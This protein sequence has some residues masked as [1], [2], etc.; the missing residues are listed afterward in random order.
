MSTPWIPTEQGAAARR[1]LR[2]T[3]SGVLATMSRE[4]PGYPFGSVTPFVTSQEG[5]PLI[6]VSTIAQHTANMQADP[7]VCLTVVESGAGN[8]QA[9]G[10]TSLVGD[11]S[12]VPA[13]A[14]EAE[15]ERYFAFFPEAREYGGTHDFRLYRIEPK[16]VRFIGGFG[17]IWWVEPQDWAVPTPAW[18]AEEADIVRHMNEDH[19]PALVAMARHFAQLDDEEAALVAVDLEGCHVRAAHGI[20]YLPFDKACLTV[21]DVRTAMI[22]LARAAQ[23]RGA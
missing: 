4:L 18:A 8:T 22:Q 12:P 9:L 17:R 10:R 16:R 7:R 5:R 14:V 23:S 20:V 19:R 2:A 21:D 13:A 15:R 11:A 6:Y 3:D 1:L